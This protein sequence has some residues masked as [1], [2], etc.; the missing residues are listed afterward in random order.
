MKLGRPDL[1]TYQRSECQRQISGVPRNFVS[2]YNSTFELLVQIVCEH[3]TA[4]T[5]ESKDFRS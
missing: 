4:Y 2:N 3:N 1:M 5:Y